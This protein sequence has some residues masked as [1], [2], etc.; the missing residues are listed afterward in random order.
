MLAGKDGR[1]VARGGAGQNIP[2]FI[3]TSSA[4][5]RQGIRAEQQHDGARQLFTEAAGSN[6]AAHYGRS[7]A[8]QARALA[9]LD[10][11]AAD[12]LYADLDVIDPAIEG[13]RANHGG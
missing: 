13:D 9:P 3:L 6:A 5:R 12:V 2:G 11:V 1:F 4:R 7:H 10:V 8:D